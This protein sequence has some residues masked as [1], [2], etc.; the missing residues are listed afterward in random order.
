MIELAVIVYLSWITYDMI[1]EFIAFHKLK[2]NP[3]LFY[4]YMMMR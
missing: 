1:S 2:E 3:E 4:K